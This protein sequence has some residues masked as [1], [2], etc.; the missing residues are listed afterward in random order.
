MFCTKCG[1]EI[2]DDSQFCKHCGSEVKV[3]ADDS[4]DSSDEPKAPKPPEQEPA[5]KRE[6]TNSDDIDLS[7]VGRTV[8]KKLAAVS[9]QVGATAKAKVKAVMEDST[10]TDS[11]PSNKGKAVSGKKG[12]TDK[13]EFAAVIISGVGRYRALLHLRHSDRHQSKG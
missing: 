4:K 1:K 6:T 10:P 5:S 13:T 11:E 12:S 3:I 9:A 8:K 2:P 7:E